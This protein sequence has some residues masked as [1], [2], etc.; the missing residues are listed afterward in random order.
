MN[1][2]GNEIRVDLVEVL[3]NRLNDAVLEVLTTMLYRNPLCRLYPD[4]IR[5]IQPYNSLPDFTMKVNNL[6]T[7]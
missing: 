1:F 7:L 3:Q 6:P 4:D 2:T 5:Y